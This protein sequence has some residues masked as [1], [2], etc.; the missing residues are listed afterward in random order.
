MGRQNKTGLDYHPVWVDFEN[1]KK[2]SAM[3]AECDMLGELVLQR[4]W[5]R[6]YKDKGY[7]LAWDD[8]E[9]V[10]LIRKMGYRQ[11]KSEIENVVE[12]CLRRGL[13]DRGL[14]DKYRILTSEKIQ[15]VYVLATYE[16]KILALDTR[17]LLINPPRTTN[18][19]KIVLIGRTSHDVTDY[20]HDFIDY[21]NE[22][23]TKESKV[24]ESTV[25]EMEVKE[26]EIGAPP[27]TLFSKEYFKIPIE[28]RKRDFWGAVESFQN[29]Y[30]SACL[31]KFF[32]IWSEY[33]PTGKRMKFELQQTW[34]LAGRLY[35]WGAGWQAVEDK[36]AQK[37]GSRM[38][39]NMDT[40][41]QVMHDLL[42]ESKA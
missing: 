1:D 19:R 24:N 7:Y 12:V 15:E 35:N 31:L 10:D 28:E 37:T 40:A 4:L 16:R 9:C 38:Q 30:D 8:D 11:T 18:A 36:K 20:Q 41:T 33:N 27:V 2:V 5:R 17:F 23:R 22:E 26:S 6:I 29:E 34:D 21:S 32:S 13:F 25:N 42:N 14:F 3:L 39:N